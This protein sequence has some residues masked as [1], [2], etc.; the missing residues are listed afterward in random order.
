MSPLN[1]KEHVVLCPRLPRAAEV[2]VDCVRLAVKQYSPQVALPGSRLNV[3]IVAAHA[4]GFA[5]VR[6]PN[7]YHFSALKALGT[8]RTFVGLSTRSS[9]V[10]KRRYQIN[11]DC[12]YGISGS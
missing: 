10:K 9:S 2:S 11:L 7:S 4:N 12:G 5:K 8:I 6:Y 3:T 1:V